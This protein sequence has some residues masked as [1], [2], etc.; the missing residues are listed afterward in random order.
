MLFVEEYMKDQS[1]IQALYRAGFCPYSAEDAA[2]DAETLLT[3]P[4]IANEIRFRLEK[5]V[6]LAE[7]SKDRVKLE[8]ARIAFSDPRD[9]FEK[10]QVQGEDGKMVT[11]DVMKDMTQIPEDAARSIDSFDFS[12]LKR[13]IKRLDKLRA[14][15]LI[16][17]MSGWLSPEEIRKSNT[18]QNDEQYTDRELAEMERIVR[19]QRNNTREGV[20]P[21]DV[22]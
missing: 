21:D 10:V 3:T 18:G 15:E 22:L 4:A 12:G 19:E 6:K 20:E 16:A 8:L 5:R 13:T 17:R 14:L 11:V 1:G 2:V 7:V 9:Y